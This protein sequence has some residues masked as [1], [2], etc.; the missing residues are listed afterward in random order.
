MVVS[1]KDYGYLGI[2]FIFVVNLF[3]CNFLVATYVYSILMML[4]LNL[5]NKER[6]NLNG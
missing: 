4:V 5:S 2:C 1:E 3:E 6:R